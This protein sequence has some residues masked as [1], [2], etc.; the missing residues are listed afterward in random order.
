ML[1]EAKKNLDEKLS[2]VF[3]ATN[4]KKENRAKIIELAKHYNLP[5]RCFIF[6]VDIDIAM[7]WNTKRTNETGKKV[8]KI[9]FYVFR[10]NYEKPTK[11]DGFQEIIEINSCV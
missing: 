2:V 9:S 1:K 4:P 7:E 10:K 11:E 3:D 6:N 5:I 8:P